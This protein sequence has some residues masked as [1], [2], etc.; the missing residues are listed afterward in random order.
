M[1]KGWNHVYT[2]NLTRPDVNGI[3]ATV[4]ICGDDDDAKE[5][6]AQMARDAGFDPFDAGPLTST[7]HL[8]RLGGLLYGLGVNVEHP[9]KILSY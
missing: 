2:Q 1:V 7:R 9:L 5:T 8:E 4:I 6:V 3:A